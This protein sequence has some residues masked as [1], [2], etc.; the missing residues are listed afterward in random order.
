MYKLTIVSGPS[1][2]T[3][4]RGSSFALQ[5]HEVSIGRQAGN[6]IVLQSTNVSKRHCVLVVSNGEVLVKDQGSS[7]GTLVNG[8]MTKL[9]AIKPGD[10]VSVGEFVFELS[11][12]IESLRTLPS[13]FRPG[14]GNVI[15]FPGSSFPSG[16]SGSPGQFSGTSPGA[17][18]SNTHFPNTAPTDLKG[19]ALWLFENHVM[20]IF[21]NLNLKHEW[22]IIGMG[23]VGVFIL[24]NLFITVYPLT[25]S[26]RE[27]VVSEVGRR[28]HFM[29]KQLVELNS[30]AL[31][32]HTET[33]T[34]IGSIERE[35]GVRVALLTDLDNRI[36]APQSRLNQYMT[37]G[38]EAAFAIRAAKLFRANRETG[39]VSE[40][41]SSTIVAIEP[42]K[43][44]NPQAGRNVVIG[45]AIVS[46][47]TTLSTPSFGDLGVVYSETL[48]L[49]GILG[50]F[51]FFILY[52][53]TLKP[54]QV[55]NDDMDKVLKGETHQV[56]QEFKFEEGN[57]LWDVI[58]STLK[59]VPRSG[60]GQG[61]D[62]LGGSTGSVEEVL[63]PVKMLGSIAKFGLVICDEDRKILFLNPVFEEISGIRADNA[64]GQELS[65]VARDQAFGTFS[66]DLFDRAPAGSEGVSEDFEFS[67]ISYRMHVAAIGAMG[68]KPRCFIL[69]AT[70]QEADT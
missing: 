33:K 32:A 6:E 11:Q 17:T 22:K 37:S 28:A 2:A 5:N 23:V 15:P 9:K 21:Y 53:L 59:R 50:M 57:Q 51:L 36:I 27:S 24:A 14:S 48:I 45:M 61:N 18:S 66:N 68:N 40:M 34:E 56:T 29:A 4:A 69:A 30:P 55:L 44:Y 1:G 49:T 43:V 26:G 10:R 60:A 39:I 65:S 46:L 25:E 12:S 20:P 47:D 42:I 13:N 38:G 31:A 41:D 62:G 52:R 3:P 58:N 16:P 8:A 63:G 7:N 54:F 64:V 67:G 70:K 19:K 35:D